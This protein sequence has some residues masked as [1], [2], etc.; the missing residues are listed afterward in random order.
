MYH[1][2]QKGQGQV[3][4]TTEDPEPRN[5]ALLLRVY[6]QD[7]KGQGLVR[8]AT[9]DPDPRK[10][11]GIAPCVPS[12]SNRPRASSTGYWR[13]RSQ[14]LHGHCSVRTIKI[15]QAKRTWSTQPNGW[16]FRRNFLQIIYGLSSHNP[17]IRQTT[18][19]IDLLFQADSQNWWEEGEGAVGS[20]RERERESGY[21]CVWS[22]CVYVWSVYVCVFEVCVYVCVFEVCVCVCVIMLSFTES[23]NQRENSALFCSL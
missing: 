15:K 3:R 12:R 17:N 20:E 14:K 18:S 8:Q 16:Y 19:G 2:D 4:Q 10:C 1:Q 6:H 7:Q 5:W 21:V 22:M 11:M 9:G 13:S 23:A